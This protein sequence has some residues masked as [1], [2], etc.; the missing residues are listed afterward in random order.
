[1]RYCELT[2]RQ[3]GWMRHPV[4]EFVREGDAV[5]YGELLAWT[6]APDRGVEFVLFYVVGNRG[7]Y[8][9]ALDDIDA[10]R[11]VRTSPVD[12][13]TFYSFVC[14]RTREADLAFR[15]AFADLELVVVYPIAF[16]GS[17]DVHLSLVG[18][19]SSF[20][21]LLKGLPSDVDA[22]VRT[23]G[24]FDHR[25]GTAASAL[26]ARQYEAVQTAVELGYYDTP[27][28]ADLEDVGGALDCAASTAWNLLSKAEEAVMRRVVS[29][30]SG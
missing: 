14:E 30:A 25:H 23:L 8:R 28:R 11:W 2:L 4:Q 18:E 13:G 15:E 20:Q 1:M 27:A 5:Q 26:T 7:P 3:P 19:A 16:D 12:D 10:V 6:A 21:Q 22:E 24:E 29:G 17:G 9:Q